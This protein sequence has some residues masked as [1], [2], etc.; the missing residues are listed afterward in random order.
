MMAWLSRLLLKVWGFRIEGD[1]ANHLPKRIFAVIPHTSGWDFPLGLLLR[2]ACSIEVGFI[3]K[4]SLFRPPF[5]WLFRWLGG[6]PVDRSTS[7][8]YV[9]A[10]AGVFEKRDRFALAIAPEGTRQKVDKLK[11]GFYHIARQAKVP[12]ILTQFNFG[13]MKIVFS[14]PL[15]ASG[16]ID[17]D[18]ET[19]YNFFRG[20][21]GRNPS[22]SFEV[23]GSDIFSET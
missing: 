20:V 6:V 13:E 3:G 22:L 1:P 16:N 11:T 9:T 14:E 17:S 8:N 7:H 15:Y 12:I 23:P 2:S 19:V 21:K 18:F 5:G 4:H 10:V